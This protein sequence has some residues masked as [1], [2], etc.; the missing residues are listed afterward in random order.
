MNNIQLIYGPKG[1]GKTKKLVELANQTVS[2]AKGD[3]VY[4]DKDMSR[5]HDLEHAIKLID[6]SEYDVCCEKTFIAFVKGILSGN[7]DIE[8]I[9][10]DGIIKI[11]K[12][13]LE[14]LQNMFEEFDRLA[15]KFNVEF[16]F[17]FSVDPQLPEYLKKYHTLMSF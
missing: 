14:Q 6:A 8:K 11:V 15:Q 9:Y 1:C 2:T 16:I 12:K 4:I 3:L 17:T 13:P 10:F 5:M 7:Y